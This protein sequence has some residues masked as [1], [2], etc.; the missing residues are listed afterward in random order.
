M[1]CYACG[2]DNSAEV[3]NC[4]SCGQALSQAGAGVAGA[5]PDFPA[6]KD[7]KA[8]ASL[9]LGILSVTALSIL[10]G[11]PAIIL[12]HLSRGSIRRSLGR[13]S[14]KGLAT[15]GLI[16][17]Y[18]SC[19]IFFVVVIGL[20][21]L[22]IPTVSSSWNI[23]RQDSV[24][25]VADQVI[26][27]REFQ[28]AYSSY[29][30]SLAADLSPEVLKAFHF[31]RRILDQMILQRVGHIEARRAGFDAPDEEVERRIRSMPAFVEND[32]FIGIERYEQLLAT[33]NLEVWEFENSVRDDI[34]IEKLQASITKD[35][36]ASGQDDRYD[37][38]LKEARR[39]ME[40][41]GEIRINEAALARI[42]EREIRGQTPNNSRE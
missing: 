41:R 14:G 32:E 13:M 10:A 26:T 39:K 3:S 5:A 30:Q 33:N 18:A 16:M 29:M 38:F 22:V 42:T 28:R 35:A 25:H 15:A 2:Y 21:Y 7:G 37:S 23:N 19:A 8:L 17:G 6:I 9:I 27:D 12:G 11:I 31:D 24:A 4:Q 34:L 20:L 36:P 1:R 40:E